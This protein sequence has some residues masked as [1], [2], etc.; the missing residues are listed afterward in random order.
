MQEVL[1]PSH[2]QDLY[3]EIYPSFDNL[4][5]TMKV[6]GD[7]EVS[8][9]ISFSNR[10]KLCSSDQDFGQAKYTICWLETQYDELSR[11]ANFIKQTIEPICFYL[12]SFEMADLEKIEDAISFS[13]LSLESGIY[14]I[15]DYLKGI[16]AEKQEQPK[17]EAF[18]MKKNNKWEKRIHK[19]LY[20]K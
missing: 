11:L 17:E 2:L 5:V 14:Q 20:G 19:L 15:W 9:K 4:P 8:F 16:L 13:Q 12:T 10:T 3:W 7:L 1:V 6:F 18:E